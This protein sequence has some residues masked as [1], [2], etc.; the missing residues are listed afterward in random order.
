MGIMEQK[1]TTTVDYQRVDM[2]IIEGCSGVYIYI[3]TEY[4]YIHTNQT[5]KKVK[6][7]WTS[8]LWR[9]IAD[10]GHLYCTHLCKS[11]CRLSRHVSGS[12]RVPHLHRL[13]LSARKVDSRSQ[14]GIKTSA[15]KA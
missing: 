12:T 9:D 14:L 15:R 7:K 8:G 2:G 13:F 3:Y 1:L 4:V 5:E 6:M 11:Y 10:F